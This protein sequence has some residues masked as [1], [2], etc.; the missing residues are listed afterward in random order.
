MTA[1]QTSE[2][3]A[4]KADLLLWL[5]KVAQETQ[6]AAVWRCLFIEM[7]ERLMAEQPVINTLNR[8]DVIALEC[9]CQLASRQTDGPK[10]RSVSIQELAEE[11]GYQE[12]DVAGYRELARILRD[13]GWTWVRTSNRPG[14]HPE[15]R[16]AMPS[17]EVGA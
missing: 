4:A 10:A 9:A 14:G 12:G 17:S 16:Y 15:H 8:D 1:P 3:L 6:G 13:A 11:L 7:R 2:Q 5:A